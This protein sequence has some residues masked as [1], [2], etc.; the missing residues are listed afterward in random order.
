MLMMQVVR[1]GICADGRLRD[2]VG[3]VKVQILDA[4]SCPHPTRR[5][6]Y[7]HAHPE[8]Y[9]Q[10]RVTRFDEKNFFRTQERE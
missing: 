7:R 3:L 1:G 4:M 10:L 2:F 5:Y 8:V 6:T 9:L